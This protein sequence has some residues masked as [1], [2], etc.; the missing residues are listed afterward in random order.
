[1]CPKLQTNFLLVSRLMLNDLNNKIIGIISRGGNLY[2][3]HFT[4]VHRVDV[5]NLVQSP[6]KDGV[7]KLWHHRLSHLNVKDVHTL[8]NMVSAWTLADFLAPHSRC[9]VKHT[10]KANNIGLH[11]QTRVEAS[12]QAFGDCAFRDVW[13]Y[14]DHIHGRCKTFCGFH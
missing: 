9:F 1:M 8:Q 5:A 2:E 14:K 11:F 4:K 10:L 12:N 7:L 13:P 3:I 6:T